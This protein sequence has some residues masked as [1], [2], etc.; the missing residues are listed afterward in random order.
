M[1]LLAVDPAASLKHGTPY[2]KGTLDWT[3]SQAIGHA[4]KGRNPSGWT[5]SQEMSEFSPAHTTLKKEGST[6]WNADTRATK[7]RIIISGTPSCFV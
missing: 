5:I 4:L 7:S 6:F 1:L 2:T 3:I